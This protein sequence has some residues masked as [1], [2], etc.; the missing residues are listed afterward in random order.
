[1]RVIGVGDNT[2]DRYLHKGMMYPGGNCVNISVL[3]HRLG[4]TAS[5]MGC[6]GS[7]VHGQLI[8]SALRKEG[9]D[10]SHCRIL[11]ARNAFCEVS[12]VNGDRVF[13]KF[14]PGVVNLLDL[15]A[16]DLAFI[17]KHDLTH[18]S[19]YS[20]TDKYLEPL[21]T[22]SK[23][24]SFDF[25]QEWEQTYL[26]EVLPWIDI[27]F[28]SNPGVAPRENKELMQWA[29]AQGPKIIVLTMGEM[30]A[31]L[32]DG[33]QFHHQ[34]VIPVENLVDTLGAG[35]AFAARFMVDHLSGLPL[36]QSLENAARS[37]SKTCEY[38]GAFGHG[39]PLV[40]LTEL[41]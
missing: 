19:I 30:G 40:S 32:F 26:Q 3:A 41:N 4:H 34:P 38:Y 9:V 1:M 31:L 17:A 28:L 16:E 29:A 12:L 14:S 24:I 15:E 8:A 11:P 33:H 22:V 13:G 39:Q 35:D 7:D 25:S 36:A 2:V 5:Y 6:L 21:R 10:I 18:T 23:T 27:A 20:F 37:A